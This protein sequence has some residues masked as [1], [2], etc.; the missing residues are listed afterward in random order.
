[1]CS[2]PL[3]SGKMLPPNSKVRDAPEEVEVASP[4]IVL[5]ITSPEVPAKESGPFGAVE[6]D[7]DQNPDT[8]KET[9]GS[10]G[11]NMVSHI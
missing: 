8:P 1:M 9:V 10:V 5:A 4:G 7:E 11:D 2:I 3:P 6:T